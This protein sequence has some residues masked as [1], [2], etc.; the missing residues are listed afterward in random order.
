MEFGSSGA[1][2]G[3]FR[4]P[5][6]VAVDKMGF[7]LVGD[8]GNGR[9]Q[10][11]RPNACIGTGLVWAHLSYHPKDAPDRDSPDRTSKR[12]KPINLIRDTRAPQGSGKLARKHVKFERERNPPKK[13]LAAL[14]CHLAELGFDEMSVFLANNMSLGNRPN[15]LFKRAEQLK[16]WEE[17]DTNREASTPKGDRRNKVRFPAGCVFLAACAAGDHDEVQRLLQNGA[18]I[19]TANIDGLTALHQNWL[20][21]VG[22]LDA[23][24]I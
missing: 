14:R 11:F 6:C 7:I 24:E 3:Q 4:T 2:R 20:Q 8:S 9:V 22:P 17:S 15:S 1:A 10:V 5:E 13:L 18:D 16:Q 23:L 19:D 12:S 21:Y